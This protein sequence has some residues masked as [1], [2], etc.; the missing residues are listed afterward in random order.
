MSN[1]TRLNPQKRSSMRPHASHDENIYEAAHVGSD[2]PIQCKFCPGQNFRRSR[3][4]FDDLKLLFFMRY[5]ARCLR[6]GQRQTVSFTV[7]GISVPSHVKQRRA[8]REVQEE[9]YWAGPIKQSLKPKPLERAA[10]QADQQSRGED[11]R[12]LE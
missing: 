3:L 12:A 1:S 4:R 11:E 6:C 7:A 8:R 10:S 5:P 2:V 9:K